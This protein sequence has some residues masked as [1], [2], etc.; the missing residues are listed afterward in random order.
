[1]TGRWNP[2]DEAEGEEDEEM[3]RA[4]RAFN[5][6][7]RLFLFFFVT[8][9]VGF[10]FT[11]MAWGPVIVGRSVLE[12]Q[13]NTICFAVFG[14]EL[15][16]VFFVRLVLAG[17]LLGDDEL[18][19]EDEDERQKRLWRLYLRANPYDGAGFVLGLAH[20]MIVVFAF[21]K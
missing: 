4:V 7:L 15:L 10:V 18:R 17:K 9:F 6:K 5:R 3:A 11:L 14:P 2:E 20:L 19:T 12:L 13:A 21:Q 8:P 16:W 1:M